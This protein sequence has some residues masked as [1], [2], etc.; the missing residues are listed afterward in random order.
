MAALSD[1]ARPTLSVLLANYNHGAFLA[2]TLDS[3]VGQQLAPSEIVIVDDASTDNSLEVI[4][5]YA[6]R[7][8]QIQV[9][10][11]PVN[12]KNRA[13]CG[14]IRSKMADETIDYI[15]IASADDR[16]QPG[17]FAAA[18]AALE[19]WP[20]A[21]LAAGY[22]RL[23]DADGNA[24]P[25]RE[26]PGYYR[27][28]RDLPFKE[29]C[30]LGREEILGRLRKQPWF[31]GGLAT[32][33]LRRTALV[34][35]GGPDDTLGMFADWF[36]VHAVS[37][38]YGMCYLPEL[39]LDFRHMPNGMGGTVIRQPKVALRQSGEVLKRMQSVRY[40]N[41]FPAAFVDAKRREFSYSALR[42]KL[43][44]FQTGFAREVSEVLEP[45]SLV[46]RLMLRLFRTLG[47]AQWLL[48]KLYCRG[49][50]APILASDQPKGD[51]D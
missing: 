28:D 30:Y 18:V 34:E 4:D 26:R 29:P 14:V 37:L 7:Y 5:A 45:R 20:Q 3:I 13:H 1:T 11:E 6:S 49:R 19:K 8:P 27:H 44:H 25:A 51:S 23:I 10:R 2:E 21:G 50:V 12:T 35:V 42:G 48:L 15:Y 31:I 46:E 22:H 32:V 17:F 24:L 36:L 39:V 9:I 43:V 41:L 47:T 33:V 38:G 40:R 16:L